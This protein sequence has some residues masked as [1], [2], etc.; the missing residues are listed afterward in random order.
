MGETG[1]PRPIAAPV[2]ISE[3]GGRSRGNALVTGVCADNRTVRP[4][5]LFAGVPGLHVHGARFSA[6]AR[7]AGAAAVL[8]DSEGAA[9]AG[10]GPLVVIDDVAAHLGAVAAQIYDHPADKLT[11]FAVTGTN[12]KTTTA[13]MLEYILSRLER[14]TGL[15]GTVALRIVG[16]DIPAS[17]TTP[18]PAELQGF[19]A[20]LVRRGGTDLVMETS[21]HALVQGRTD[22]IC[23]DVAGYTNLTQ[24]HLDFHHT[25]EEYFAAKAT[26]F[27]PERARRAVV[28]VDDDWGRR[29]VRESADDIDVIALAIRS[30]LPAGMRGWQ[31]SAGRLT[32]TEGDS[33]EVKTSLP[34]D[35]N[36]A[37]AALA[38]TMA[39]AGGVAIDDVASLGVIAPVVPGRM[40]VISTRPRVVVDFAHNTDA[41]VKAMQALRPSTRGRLIVLTGAAGERDQ[42]KRPAMGEAVARYADAV[43]ITDDDPHGEDPASIR[44]DV[45]E[46]TR[47]HKTPVKEI[48]NRAE[49][50]RQSIL[51]ASVQDTILLAG[52]GHETIQD[53]GGELIQLDDRAEA[54]RV[55]A[56]RAQEESE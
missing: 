54:R 24:D 38:A 17:L 15:I 37:N 10:D 3:L 56:L 12:G 27:T 8:T 32:S 41:L 11:T 4:G 50:I 40:E 34:G 29:L 13:F 14:K 33:F 46:G 48:A 47:R 31:F 1:L 52:R 36:I 16:E 35:F 53:V 5:D 25:M 43:I 30:E 22:P 42:A 49:A 19:L 26:L 39:L 55:L 2:S 23:Y 44:A 51:D 20:E 45:L 6:Q 18:M 7:A 21:S 28:V 9:L